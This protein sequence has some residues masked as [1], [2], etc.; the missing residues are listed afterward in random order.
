M[1]RQDNRAVYD[2]LKR[3]LDVAGA[4]TALIVFAPVLVIAALLIKLDGGPIF[5]RQK[6]MGRKGKTFG[7]LKLR[8]MIPNAHKMES[9]LRLEQISNGGYGVEGGYSDP[10]ITKLGK[11]LRLLN[12]DELP[13]FVNVL[14]GDMSL[15][16]PRPVPHE[17][18][19]L[20]GDKRDAVLSVRP[21]IT[22][23]WQV[24]RRMYMDYDRRVELDHHY[25]R[26]RSLLLDA[27]I[28]FVT[29]ISML[30]SDYNSLNKPLPPP[31]A[32]VLVSER[33][34]L[35]SRREEPLVKSGT[36]GG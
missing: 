17:E 21:G 30:T 35:A 7:M 24:K 27:Y 13:Q 26:N 16:G 25:V 32:G 18:S 6:R 20:Y 10:R 33:A 12:I 22:G 3:W 11:L 1:K 28:L 23:Y 8:T 5:F 36:D 2:V 4:I 19:L 9:Y 31:T 29:P 14:K 34:R 15:V